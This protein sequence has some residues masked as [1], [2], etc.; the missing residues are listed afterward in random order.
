MRESLVRWLTKKFNSAPARGHRGE[1]RLLAHHLH[2][3]QILM[4]CDRIPRPQVEGPR[5]RYRAGET[6]EH[7]ELKAAVLAWV[8]E[9]DAAARTERSY[10]DQAHSPRADVMAPTLRWV[11]ECGNTDPDHVIAALRL[12]AARFVLFPF[13]DASE[14]LSH[15][16]F[17][18]GLPGIEPLR[19]KPVLTVPKS[20]RG[21]PPTLV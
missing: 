13:P 19:R 9:Y 14:W 8:L 2:E 21:R 15:V 4:R 17:V 3:K 18:V 1:A 6:F 5:N 12:G 11:I 20:R 16:Y 10:L 7:Q